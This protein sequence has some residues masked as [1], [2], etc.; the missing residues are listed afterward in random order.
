MLCEAFL[1]KKVAEIEQLLS[2]RGVEY[3][4][5]SE[6]S[7]KDLFAKRIDWPDAVAIVE[8]TGL[9][10]SDAMILNA[11][12]CSRTSFMFSADFD[13]GYA[14]LS[15]GALKDVVMPDSIAREYRHFHFT[16]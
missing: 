16:S 3:I 7:Q 5:Q 12:Q 1:S 10:V 2:E 13:V 11:V 15:D 6:P 14:T 4:S 9:A 8:K